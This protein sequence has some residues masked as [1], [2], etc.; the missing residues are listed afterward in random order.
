MQNIETADC[1]SESWTFDDIVHALRFISVPTDIPIAGIS[2]DSRDIAPGEAFIALKGEHANGHDYLQQAYDRG[3]IL[4]IVEDADSPALNGK[5]Y[6]RVPN[7]MG[8]LSDLAQFARTRTPATVVC[9]SGSVGKTT[10]RT[11]IAELLSHAG[12]TVSTKK[13]F[14]GRI[15]LPLSLTALGQQTDFGVFE[16]GIDAPGTMQS[17]AMLCN[18]HVAVFTPLAPAHLEA[19][20][21]MDV[22]AQE[23]ALLCSGLSPDGIAVVESETNNNFPVIA[24]FAKEYGAMDVVTVGFTDGARIRITHAEVVSLQGESKLAS[25]T[26]CV[27]LNAGEIKFEYTIP[28]IGRH[29]IVDSAIA[30]VSAICAAFD[31]MWADIISKHAS[32]IR[33]VFL[34]YMSQLQL[35]EGRGKIYQL[36][37]SEGRHISLVDDAY[38]A[39]L[40]SM[41]AGLNA[42]ELSKGHRK[43]A[44]VGD[45]LEL[46]NMAKLSH[47]QLFDAL[48]NSHV[49]KVFCIGTLS[50]ASFAR[51]PA[52]KQGGVAESI[53][54]LKEFLLSALVDGDIVWVKGSHSTGLHNLVR[55]L[56]NDG[57]ENSRIAAA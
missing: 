13:N 33:H 24:H 44:V 23:K 48:G 50:A 43:I 1:R 34:P 25:D 8:A 16:I 29:A 57:A 47:H 39:N 46:G 2:I 6:L 27:T 54:G 10:I 30:F 45:M 31:G 9:V 4:A 49:D 32:D 37:L 38:N 11:W 28:S 7:T 35:L 18:P 3:A 12:V 14:N 55:T 22:L 52:L 21:S 40:S 20:G 15:G 41:L 42:L 53:A 5:S 26:A 56:I 17:L 19:F 51:L 36:N